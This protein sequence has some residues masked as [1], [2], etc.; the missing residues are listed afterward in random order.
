MITY[1]DVLKPKS[2]LLL[3]VVYILLLVGVPYLIGGIKL[4]SFSLANIVSLIVVYVIF[5]V[6]IIEI[7]LLIGLGKRIIEL[8]SG[9]K[10]IKVM[11]ISKEERKGRLKYY[12]YTSLYALLS[13][14][15]IRFVLGIKLDMLSARLVTVLLVL[16]YVVLIKYV[17]GLKEK[18]GISIPGEKYKEIKEDNEKELLR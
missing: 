17:P 8:L 4:S 1:K 14:F 9:K 3:F 6:L 12:L 11:K 13:I 16:L 7:I 2:L 18:L 10:K 5:V 15:I